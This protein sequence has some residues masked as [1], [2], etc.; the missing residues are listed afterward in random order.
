MDKPQQPTG[1]KELLN[2]MMTRRWYITA[3]VLG[4][5]ILIILGIFMS[6]NYGLTMAGEWKELLLLLLGAFIGSG[7]ITHSFYRKV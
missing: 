6:M 1:F 7:S 2:A 5:F 3:A 4:G